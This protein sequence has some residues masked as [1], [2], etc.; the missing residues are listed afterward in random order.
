MEKN[1]QFSKQEIKNYV[2]INLLMN[3]SVHSIHSELCK[4]FGNEAPSRA[5][6]F[7]WKIKKVQK[8]L[9]RN[10]QKEPKE[11]FIIL[12]NS[13]N[14]MLEIRDHIWEFPSHV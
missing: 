14:Q 2:K 4:F 6:L 5:T 12:M 10:M 1:R 3:K 11:L 13:L 8:R 7:R 9:K